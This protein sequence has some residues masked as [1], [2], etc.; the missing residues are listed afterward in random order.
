[1]ALYTIGD[2][3]LS[4]GTDKPM[5]IFPGWENY[6]RRIE[7]GWRSTVAPEDTVV[8]AG[9]VSWAMDLGECGAD[10]TFLHRLPG[11][12]ILL[13]GNHDYWFSTRGKVERYLEEM[14]FSSIRILF[15]NAYACEGAALCGTR[16]WINEQGEQV[17]KKV[18]NREAGRLRM[19]L[20]AGRKT[21][22]EPVAFLHYPPLYAGTE[23]PEILDV[24]R[25]YGVRECY[26]GHIHGRAASGAFQG[27]RYGIRFRMVSGDQTGFVPVRVR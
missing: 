18:L 7:D 22:L 4:L 15:N 27:V 8:V 19:S 17:D 26:Y 25:E 20:E 5:D 13:K 14:G 24:L 12:K 1:M 23:C 3:H 11:S 16:G 2:L 10:F 21:G 9:D 6:I